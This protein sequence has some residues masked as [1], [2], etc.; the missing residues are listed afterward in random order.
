MK[1]TF[2][3]LALLSMPLVFSQSLTHKEDRSLITSKSYTYYNGDCMISKKT[4]KKLLKDDQQA[5]SDFESHIRNKSIAN[6]INGLSGAL[7]AYNLINW[8]SGDDLSWE[9]VGVNLALA[10]PTY[11]LNKKAEKM[12]NKV[13]EQFNNEVSFKFVGD[14][15]GLGVAVRF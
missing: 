15:F 13:E 4:Y 1:T 8:I 7:G 14:Q 5:L 9:L 10:I 11:F 6:I 2:L 3:L 12:L